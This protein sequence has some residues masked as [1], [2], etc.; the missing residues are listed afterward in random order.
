MKI[1]YVIAVLAIILLSVVTVNAKEANG[2]PFEELRAAIQELSDR[3]NNIQL[4]PG[5]QGDTGDV[6][7][8][9]ADGAD[10]A[11]GADGADGADGAQGIQG[12]K[13]DKGEPSTFEPI[14]LVVLVPKSS[15]PPIPAGLKVVCYDG[16]NS[17]SPS[18]P[19]NTCPVVKWAGNTYWAYSYINNAFAMKIVAYR[20][21]DNSVLSQTHK[22][23]A[24]YLYAI[25]IDPSTRTVTLR[26]QGGNAVTMTYPEPLVLS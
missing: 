24:R 14:P 9:G 10:G 20:D 18:S 23:G 19:S 6:G 2:Q 7:P 3:I 4:T 17:P 11:N 16:P 22:A 12:I 21:V 1:R 5:P 26:G 15:H 13:G 8:A 25:S